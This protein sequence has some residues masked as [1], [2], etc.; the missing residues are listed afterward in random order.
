MHCIATKAF[1]YQQTH[2]GTYFEVVCSIG[3]G[4]GVVAENW[5][6]ASELAFPAPMR[7]SG[8]VKIEIHPKVSLS[9]VL[10]G[11]LVFQSSGWHPVD[12][13]LIILLHPTFKRQKEALLMPV[14]YAYMTNFAKISKFLRGLD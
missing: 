12:H 10:V 13:I 4:A 2:E 3:A 5:L 9:Q 6:K 8:S 11:I 7:A 14:I 1:S